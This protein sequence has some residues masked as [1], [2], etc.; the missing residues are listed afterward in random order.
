MTLKKLKLLPEADDNYC[1]M[2]LSETFVKRL[3]CMNTKME[4]SR[5]GDTWQSGSKMTTDLKS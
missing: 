5:V 4:R 1:S 3:N 2:F